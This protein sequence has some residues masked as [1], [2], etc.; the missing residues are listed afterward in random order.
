[1]ITFP[2]AHLNKFQEV[3]IP[4]AKVLFERYGYKAPQGHPDNTDPN[5]FKTPSNLGLTPTETL[6]AGMRVAVRLNAQATAAAKQAEAADKTEVEKKESKNDSLVEK[7][8][9][10]AAKAEPSKE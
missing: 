10:A 1:M 3:S 2:A 9:E 5:H 6:A 8:S 7:S 4:K